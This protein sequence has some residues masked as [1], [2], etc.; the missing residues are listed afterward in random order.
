MFQL[1]PWDAIYTKGEVSSIV[2]INC[3]SWA[4]IS[5]L[6]RMGEDEAMDEEEDVDNIVTK[7]Y[8]NI[9]DSE[10]CDNNIFSC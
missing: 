5:L 8:I 10:S 7:H 2:L 1:A 3:R 4:L 6:I 9:T